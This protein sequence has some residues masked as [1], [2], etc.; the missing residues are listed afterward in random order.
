MRNLLRDPIVR[1]RFIDG[2]TGT[3]SL[4]AL[5]EALFAD[6]IE[7]FVAVRTHQRHVWHAFLCMLGAI[8]CIRAGLDKPPS[9]AATW[10]RIL[11][12]LTPDFP[13]GEPWSLV[14]PPDKPAFLQPVVGPLSGL[15]PLSTPDELD[16]LVTAKNHDLKGARMADA[17]PDDWLFAL[18]SLQTAEGFLGAGNF[19]ISRMNG[20]FANRPGVGLVPPGRIGKH[21]MRDIGQLITRFE[22]TLDAY[23]SYDED[24]PAL[25]W[26]LPWDGVAT[27][28][29]KG[30][31]PYYIEICRR[32]RLSD[33][34]GSIV[35]WT[36]NSKA[37]RVG[38]TKEEGGITGDPWTPIRI[39][40]EGNKALTIDARGFD[41]RRL[42]D[43]IAGQGYVPAPLQTFG[44]GEGGEGW[45]LL[46]RATARG[47][48]KTEGY[49]E[50][51]EPI[52]PRAVLRLKQGEFDQLA[53]IAQKR[54]AQAGAVRSAL[55]F[56]LMTLFQNGPEPSDY[57]P[58]DPSSSRHADPYLD[59]FQGRVDEH[60][61]ERLFAEYE[62]ADG[63]PA[64][65]LRV[66]WLTELLGE[67][68]DLLR[69]AESASPTSAVR[70][71]RA[72]VR[73]DGA[74]N[75]GYYGSKELKD[76]IGRNADAA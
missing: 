76:F 18:L 22:A 16:M 4:P 32:V 49:H 31:H 66:A 61:F 74:L 38:M 12:A 48:G 30:L 7:S 54:I 55:R 9:D 26:L 28:P 56:G 20:G 34:N 53:G 35:A 27:L 11:A 60:F 51:R 59:R 10:S 41:Y 57:K 75:R 73:A 8:A 2:S 40:A 62:V 45:T 43:I 69:M 68:Q 25:I 14:S 52:P 21:V 23:D 1:M 24:G 67:A 63:A 15:K 36:G 5:Y 44:A 70:R 3:V 65:A 37:M 17:Q 50:R 42:S 58:Q 72:I 39:A 47:Q 46:C 64:L 19:G 13:D 71:H 6:R 33:E 29:R